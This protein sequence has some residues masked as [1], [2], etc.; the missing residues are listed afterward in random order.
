VIL[1]LLSAVC[2]VGLAGTTAA[3]PDRR[4]EAEGAAAHRHEQAFGVTDDTVTLRVRSAISADPELANGIEIATEDGVVR[5]SGV[6]PDQDTKQRV[7]AVAKKVDGV[8]RVQ[9][10]LRVTGEP[11]Q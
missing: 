1:R 5:L 10:D 8:E 11:R 9:N 2:V 7:E 3:C 4:G 6:V